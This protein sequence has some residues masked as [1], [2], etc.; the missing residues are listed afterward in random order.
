MSE[1][2]FESEPSFANAE[3]GAESWT[4]V[5]LETLVAETQLGTTE[6]GAS[7]DEDTIPLI[8]M[9]NLLWGGD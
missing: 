9:G 7:E 5:S 2:T 4:E 6:R 1:A 3:N 8:K